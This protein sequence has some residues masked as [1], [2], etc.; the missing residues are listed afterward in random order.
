MWKDFFYFSKS[1]QIAIIILIAI[2]LITLIAN[3]FIHH[4]QTREIQEGTAFLKKAEAFKKTLSERDSL[5]QW[6]RHYSNAFHAKQKKQDQVSL[7]KFDPNMADSAQLIKLGLKPFVVSNILK[8]RSKGGY[9]KTP[10]DFGKTYGISTGQFEKLQPYIEITSTK[11]I[12]TT[13]KVE[14]N[15]NYTTFQPV[16]LNTADSSNLV[17]IK[18]IG[19]YYALGIIRWRNKLGGYHSVDQLAE[20][21]GM[22]IE[23]LEKIRPYCIVNRSLVRRIKINS[24]S[25]E[26]LNAHPYISFYEAKAIYELRRRKGK[27]KSALDLLETGT[28]NKEK[29]DKIEPYLSFE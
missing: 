16:E 27:L 4:S 10:S 15:N 7:F 5:T 11:Q 25:V 13:R 2:I 14:E 9:Y 17:R 1:Q 8:Y 24:A 22:K 19:P 12:S 23:I 28:L 20:V 29:Y 21:K 26:K 18:G 3:W 6:K